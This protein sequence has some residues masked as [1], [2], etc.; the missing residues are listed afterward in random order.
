MAER[1]KK[2]YFACSIRGEQGGKEEKELIVGTMKE[3]GHIVLSEMFAGLD[4]S[5]N[6]SNDGVPPAEIYQQDMAWVEEADIVV[7]DVSRASTGLGYEIGWKLR[8]DGP[9]LALCLESRYQGLS[10]M[11]KGC[12][13]P[14]FRLRRWDGTDNPDQLREVLEQ[15]LGRFVNAR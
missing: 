14:R 5:R 4:L 9:V 12:T 2:I 6:Q 10:N 11:I 3:L 8:S 7:A 15:E 1:P 13:E